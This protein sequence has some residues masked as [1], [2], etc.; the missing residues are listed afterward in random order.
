MAIRDRPAI[1]PPL[2]HSGDVVE[3]QY[4]LRPIFDHYL[5]LF[6]FVDI[7]SL[8]S[9]QFTM[10]LSTSFLLVALLSCLSSFSGNT[11]VKA[12]LSPDKDT[13]NGGDSKKFIEFSD[14]TESDSDSDDSD[15]SY[16]PSSHLKKSIR[17]LTS[18]G[19]ATTHHQ[20]P[21]LHLEDA[22]SSSEEDEEDDEDNSKPAAVPSPTV[23]EEEDSKP[24]A[25]PSPAPASTVKDSKPA[26]V[27]SP[28]PASAGNEQEDSK[29]ASTVNQEEDSK[30]AAVPSPTPASTAEEA[31]EECDGPPVL[32]EFEDL[33]E[34]TKLWFKL[35]LQ[36]FMAWQWIQWSCSG[37]RKR[38]RDDK[39]GD[40]DDGKGGSSGTG[41]AVRAVRRRTGGHDGLR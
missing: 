15:A 39:E 40:G 41:R 27:P 18:P 25:L 4:T 2:K 1:A 29:P 26:A 17:G 3:N 21:K 12:T 22:L 37:A 8:Y 20:M 28:T 6:H 31:K 9:N 14:E 10:K 19:S 33:T 13:G 38:G 7:A 30:P 23:N 32:T 11:L 5:Q 24:A 34:C 16:K 35:L 36:Y